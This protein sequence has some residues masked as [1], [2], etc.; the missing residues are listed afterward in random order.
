MALPEFTHIHCSSRYDR[1]ADELE[2]DLDDW[3][4][5]S[6]IIT[7]TEVDM[8]RAKG[9]M[10]EKGWGHYNY[11]KPDGQDEAAILWRTDTWKWQAGW[12][13]KLNNKVF[14]NL[15]GKPADPIYAAS[16]VLRHNRTGHRLLV[17]VAHLPAHV[18]GK[19]QWN[20][21]AAKWKARKNAYLSSLRAWSGHISDQDRKR[22]ADGVLV[23]ADWN[24]NL[25]EHWVRAM[26]KDHWT[27]K[28]IQ[29]WTKFPTEGGSLSGGPVGPLGAPGK[30]SGDRIIDGS[31]YRDLKIDVHPDLMARVDSS[32][33]RPYKER[34]RFKAKAEHP[35]MDHGD[36]DVKYG[37]AWWG[38]GDYSDDELYEVERARGAAGGE[39]L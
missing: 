8:P 39:V 5:K 1:K 38:F 17:S 11:P 31:L 36:G 37:D 27:A 14:Y 35:D 13:R 16:V 7:L 26:L 18:E 21:D 23:V 30:S 28:Y 15:Q 32:K 3:M 34:F 33:H 22:R 29:A 12:V 10:R 19:N 9:R 4:G 24:L 2:S 25:K 20:T 6:S